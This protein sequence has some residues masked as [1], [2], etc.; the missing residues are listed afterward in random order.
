MARFSAVLDACVLVPI[1]QADALLRL[2]AAGLYRPVWSARILDEMV[3][4]LERVHPDMAISGAARRRASVMNT[5]FADACVDEGDCSVLAGVELPDADDAHVVAAAVWGRADVI[6]TNNLKDFPGSALSRLNLEAQHPDHFLLGQLDLDAD[7]VMGALSEQAA[8]TRSPALDLEAVLER[9][10]RCGV[11]DFS[12]AA[13]RQ[14]W[15][16]ARRTS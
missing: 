14:I 4:A 15:R 6:V 12:T 5:A 3:E 9:L 10:E 1:T 2:A 11:A 13:R 7:R 16:V 8:A